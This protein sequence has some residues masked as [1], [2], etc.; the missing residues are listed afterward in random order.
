MRVFNVPHFLIIKDQFYACLE[1]LSLDGQKTCLVVYCIYMCV[2]SNSK[3]P[4]FKVFQQDLRIQK[5]KRRIQLDQEI[6]IHIHFMTW[7]CKWRIGRLS[8]LTVSLLS[9]WLKRL[10]TSYKT[11]AG[12]EVPRSIVYRLRFKQG[13]MGF[14]LWHLSL[15]EPLQYSSNWVTAW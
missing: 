3:F 8:T 6:L 15:R 9:L 14:L 5:K 4:V 2:K 13:L 10:M 11:D 12:K 7:L 1:G